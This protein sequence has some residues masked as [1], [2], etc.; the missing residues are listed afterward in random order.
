[1]SFHDFGKKD[2]TGFLSKLATLIEKLQILGRIKK[3]HDFNI[4]LFYIDDPPVLL[5]EVG[6]ILRKPLHLD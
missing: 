2:L 5:K 6:Y 4:E 1:M 3:Y